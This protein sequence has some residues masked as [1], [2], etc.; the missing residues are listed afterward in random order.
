MKKEEEEEEEKKKKKINTYLSTITFN[1]KGLN[2]A[3]KRHTV[4]FDW[5]R[6]Q[7]GQEN[8]TLSYAIYKKL[9]SDQKTHTN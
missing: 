5:T 7:N 8:K 9:T 2:A 6:N 1:A 4:A 3:I